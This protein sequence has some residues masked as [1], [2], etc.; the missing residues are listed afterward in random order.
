[1]VAEQ[2]PFQGRVV[3][4]DHR[5]RV[6]REDV[7]GL[8]ELVGDRVVG[9]VGVDARLEPRPGVHELH[10]LE[11]GCDLAHHGLRGRQRH[12]VFRHPGGYGLYAGL[13]PQVADAGAVPDEVVFLGGLD[14][15]HPHGGRADVHQLH[16]GEGRFQGPE[17]V[18]RE[19]VELHAEARHAP[20]EVPNGP[21]VVVPAPVRVDE[22]V[23]VGA[24]PG[25]SAVYARRDGGGL[26]GVDDHPVLPPEEAVDPTGVVADVLVRG[27]EAGVD[28]LGRHVCPQG[29]LAPIHLSGR[30]R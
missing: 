21:V 25:L 2:G 24:A 20:G 8:H 12:L 11:A 6:H 1:M 16:S 28:V 14:G 30:E 15:P 13:G 4:E 26:V 18:H 3:A 7:P 27:E 19:V 10:E 9:P 23:A 22:V 5:E 29:V 17:L